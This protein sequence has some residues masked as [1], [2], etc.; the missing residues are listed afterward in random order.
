MEEY[1]HIVAGG[2]SAGCVMAGRLSEDPATSVCL[3]ECGGAGNNWFVNVPAGIA[4][5]VPTKLNNW[6]FETVPQA[7]LDGRRGYQ[8]RG[9]AL[10]GSSAI[11]AMIYTRGQPW[12]YDHWVALGNRGWAFE[13][14]L[15]YFKRSENNEDFRDEQPG[16]GGPLTVADL[17]NDS[18]APRMFIEAARQ[19]QFRTTDDFNGTNQDGVGCYQV[20]QKN[21]EHWS[22]ARAYIEPHRSRKNLSVLTGAAATRIVFESRRARGVNTRRG[23]SGMLV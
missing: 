9:K 3:L 12:D 17:R 8:P 4:L 2:G 22:A 23:P 19:A 21:G 16:T 10:G 11:N 6:A 18:P 1:D 7:G 13:G 14:V 15:P 20:T 5:M